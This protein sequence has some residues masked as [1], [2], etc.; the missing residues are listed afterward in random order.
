MKTFYQVILTIDAGR[1]T[2]VDFS[3]AT[4][5]V[6]YAQ[7]MLHG[8]ILSNPEVDWN[9][10]VYTDILSMLA[11]FDKAT[12]GYNGKANRITIEKVNH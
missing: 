5:A 4:D 6:N 10:F 9:E 12:V 2:R 1:E 7:G 11:A 3:K 8:I